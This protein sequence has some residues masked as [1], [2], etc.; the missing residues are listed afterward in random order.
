MHGRNRC[1]KKNNRDSHDIQD[2]KNAGVGCSDNFSIFYPGHLGYPCYFFTHTPFFHA[3][4]MT[5]CDVTG[6]G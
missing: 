4:A 1:V 3:F 6:K 5:F 2:R